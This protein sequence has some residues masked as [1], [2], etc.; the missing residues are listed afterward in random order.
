MWAGVEMSLDWRSLEPPPVLT[1]W[2]C[3]MWVQTH[4]EA[5]LTA[6]ASWHL[7]AE[8]PNGTAD[9]SC[10]ANWASSYCLT[11]LCNQPSGN[12][13]KNTWTTIC[14]TDVWRRSICL[15]LYVC[16]CECVWGVGGCSQRFSA[17]SL[18]RGAQCVNKH[19][20]AFVNQCSTG[21]QSLKWP[22]SDSVWPSLLPTKSVQSVSS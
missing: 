17:H 12:S 1:G 14:C 15:H 5:S 8:S 22:S 18:W 19:S 13:V 9:V 4:L 20:S 7:V 10:R 16:V 6:F 21:F 3:P 2:I 11:G